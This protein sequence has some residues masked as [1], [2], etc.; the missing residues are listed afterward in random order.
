MNSTGLTAF[1]HF[2]HS[3]FSLFCF[4]TQIFLG[5]DHNFA[6]LYLFPLWL[7]GKLNLFEEMLQ[8]IIMLN[9]LIILFSELII[10]KLEI[11]DNFLFVS[12]LLLKCDDVF[13]HI[14]RF[15]FKRSFVLESL[16]LWFFL[17]RL[18]LNL[19]IALASFFVFIDGLED[20]ILRLLF[21]S[22]SQTYTVL[23]RTHLNIGNQLKANILLCKIS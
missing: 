15:Y 10:E 17:L 19:L 3:I 8:L 6:C 2:F 22:W 1:E 5:S 12:I 7:K 14:D 21:E 9:A 16:I 4:L 18:T 23:N 20:D 13:K 11:F